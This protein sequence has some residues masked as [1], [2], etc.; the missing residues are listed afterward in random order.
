MQSRLAW[1]I[2]TWIYHTKAAAHILLAELPS[3]SPE[4]AMT[5]KGRRSENAAAW[6]VGRV[7]RKKS[8][9]R[10]ESSRVL[11]IMEA[12]DIVAI[13]VTA[14]LL[15]LLIIASQLLGMGL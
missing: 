12:R 3:T 6:P 10:H 9:M 8:T 2:H 14:G 1:I 7:M 15:T 11:G 13:A 5:E 4:R